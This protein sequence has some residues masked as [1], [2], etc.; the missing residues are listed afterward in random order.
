M[1]GKGHSVRG[2]H[3]VRIGLLS[4]GGGPPLLL[5]HGGMTQLEAWA[6]A[7]E[8]LQ[9]RWQVTAMDR[10]GRGRSG[11]APGYAIDAEYDDVA[12]VTGAL[13]AEHGGPVDVLGHSYGATCVLGAA[14]RGAPFRRVVLYEPAAQQTVSEDWVRRASA[15]ASGGRAGHAMFSFLTEIV[16]LTREQVG[17][18]ATRPLA[19]DVR[20]IVRD[21]LPRE[22]TALLSTDVTAGAGAITCPVLLLLGETSP[23]WA[24]EITRDLAATITGAQVALLPG[25]GHEAIDAAPVLIVAVLEK[26]LSDHATG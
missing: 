22:A 6:P 15:M 11:D 8:L 25:Q 17:E 9:E 18:L 1:E 10:R 4:A 23:G 24:R 12:A 14:A 20:A 7:W 21:T 26:F 13:A 5:V 3:G 19:Y 2:A 16:G